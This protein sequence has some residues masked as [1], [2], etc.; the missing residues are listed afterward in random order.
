MRSVELDVEDRPDVSQTQILID[1]RKRIRWLR[2]KDKIEQNG[3]EEE[4]T[5]R[6]TKLHEKERRKMSLF[7]LFLTE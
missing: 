5:S 4:A 1:H 6:S 7:S 3:G 2:Q